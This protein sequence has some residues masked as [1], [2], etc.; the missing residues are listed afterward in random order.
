MKYQNWWVIKISALP[1]GRSWLPN[2]RVV[3]FSLG[4][5][6]LGVQL[7]AIS[8]AFLSE[9]LFPPL[10]GEPQNLN[11]CVPARLFEHML[12]LGAHCDRVCVCYG[13]C[14]RV[15]VQGAPK[16]GGQCDCG[17]RAAE[18]CVTSFP[19]QPLCG[20]GWAP[21][22]PTALYSMK[23]FFFFSNT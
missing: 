19:V 5:K 22:P 11:V 6:H 20:S 9:V 8:L 2:G 15:G 13:W 12:C 7:S 10:E 1:H 21:L 16:Q 18:L 14:R 3:L 23:P 4:L 17:R